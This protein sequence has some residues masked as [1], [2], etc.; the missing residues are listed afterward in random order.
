MKKYIKP[1]ATVI[2]IDTENALMAG[3]MDVTGA[4]GFGG[5]AGESQG[6]MEAD[7]KKSSFD[8]WEED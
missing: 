2:V 1:T 7:S 5:Y 4:T 8:V 6:G 3:S